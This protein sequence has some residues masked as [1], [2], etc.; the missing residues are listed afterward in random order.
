MCPPCLVVAMPGGPKPKPAP[1]PPPNSKPREEEIPSL[2][3]IR[4]VTD[5]LQK[6][7]LRGQFRN[8]RKL[9][10]YKGDFHKFS[11][12]DLLRDGRMENSR[13]HRK[14]LGLVLDDPDFQAWCQVREKFKGCPPSWWSSLYD[15]LP[16]TVL[17]MFCSS[18]QATLPNH[19]KDENPQPHQRIRP[20]E[21]SSQPPRQLAVPQ[22]P[23]SDMSNSQLSHRWT[24]KQPLMAPAPPHPQAQA[25]G[26]V[27]AQPNFFPQPRKPEH[28]QLHPQTF[29]ERGG[30]Y[31]HRFGGFGTFADQRPIQPPPPP[32]HHAFQ[33]W[34]KNFQ[35]KPFQ[36]VQPRS[37][38][39][40]RA[41]AP[42]PRPPQQG[43]QYSWNATRLQEGRFRSRFASPAAAATPQADIDREAREEEANMRRKKLEE[44][45][46]TKETLEKNIETRAKARQL[47]KKLQKSSSCRESSPADAAEY[48]KP[49]AKEQAHKPDHPSTVER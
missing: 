47:Q 1:M 31:H 15:L 41:P 34:G 24:S 21:S 17:S 8:G 19:H 30:P 2:S 23:K 36:A 10:K 45:E 46:K 40:C 3:L 28:M 43:S 42:V 44:I 11:Y 18:F 7:H 49:A 14:A 48:E 27:Y 37:Q 32:A 35:A 12:S 39:Q 16:P 33:H 22:V 5:V 25:G 38:F 9:G 20:E 26:G 6:L 4:Q 13:V 29:E